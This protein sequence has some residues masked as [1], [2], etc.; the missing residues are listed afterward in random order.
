MLKRIFNPKRVLVFLALAVLGFFFAAW[1]IFLT[2][3]MESGFDLSRELL[4]TDIKIVVLEPVA[5]LAP[6]A[7]NVRWCLAAAYAD[8]HR[9]DEAR[10]EYTASLQIIGE[11]VKKARSFKEVYSS[12]Q[13]LKII[14]V[15]RGCVLRAKGDIEGAI[16][17]LFLS[18]AIRLESSSAFNA[19]ELDSRACYDLALNM[20]N[21]G[22]RRKAEKYLKLAL[23]FDADN[24]DALDGLGMVFL[25]KDEVDTAR[26]FFERAL[27]V[28]PG[29]GPAWDHLKKLDLKR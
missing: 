5:A 1:A 13:A 17:D 7:G 9:Y 23:V 19:R 6:G 16:L 3:F 21:V 29:F 14:Y 4:L 18:L 12:R 24:V 27:K 25:R 15:D 26:F 2:A 11:Y 22:S 28:H 8:A 20:I 10:R